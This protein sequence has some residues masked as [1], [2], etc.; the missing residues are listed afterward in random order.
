MEICRCQSQNDVEYSQF[1]GNFTSSE[2]IPNGEQGLICIHCGQ[3]AAIKKTKNEP[4]KSLDCHLMDPLRIGQ[5]GWRL[6]ED[7]ED[8]FRHQ[9]LNFGCFRVNEPPNKDEFEC[10]YSSP[11]EDL[12]QVWLLWDRGQ[13]CGF[14]TLRVE[15]Q[16]FPEHDNLVIV[17][18]AFIR[19]KAR[20]QGYLTSLIISL[21]QDSSTNVEVGFSE[22][23]SNKML[24]AVLR[25]LRKRP[26]FRQRVWLVN[27]GRHERQILWWSSAK[28]ARQR[29]M[30]L[31]TIL[32]I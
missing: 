5:D 31:A 25:L 3:C 32:R 22:P 11:I 29:S 4:Y 10:Y 18:T 14:V 27:E 7:P 16:A 24:I 12:D 13:A 20:G 6:A 9:I 1:G 19:K 30:D 8:L 23:I 2:I 17:D 21:M 26:D 28:L 15:S